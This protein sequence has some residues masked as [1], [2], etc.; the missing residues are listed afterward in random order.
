MVPHFSYCP[1]GMNSIRQQ[2]HS[3]CICCIWTYRFLLKTVQ[4]ADG[5]SHGIW[6]QTL[7][8][9]SSKVLSKEVRHSR[10]EKYQSH[11]SW[12]LGVHCHRL[13]TVQTV[14]AD[15]A[16]GSKGSGKSLCRVL[17]IGIT[18]VTD[19]NK[20]KYWQMID[21]CFLFWLE[22]FWYYAMLNYHRYQC[23]YESKICVHNHQKNSMVNLHIACR[24]NLFLFT[25]N[26]YF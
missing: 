13:L 8:C 9:C 14:S 12:H 18:V 15:F 23:H 10:L 24:H 22:N 16:V 7:Q 17:K 2:I 3:N 11:D 6:T 21:S 26:V 4:V 5:A 1:V 19:V 20:K 25:I